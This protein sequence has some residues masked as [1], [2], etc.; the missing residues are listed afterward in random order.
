MALDR[1]SLDRLL[2]LAG[3]VG[4]DLLGGVQLEPGD[5]D[6]LVAAAVGH[7]QCLGEIGAEGDVEVAGEQVAGAARQQAHRRAGAG[8]G[9]RDRADGAVAAERADDV[10]ARLDRL[11]GL[12]GAG[13]VDRRLDEERLFPAQLAAGRGQLGAGRRDAVEL[14]R[15]DDDGRTTRRGLAPFVLAEAVT[16]RPGRGVPSPR[17]TRSTQDESDDDGDE[18]E[19]E[20]DRD[21]QHGPVRHG[22]D[23]TPAVA[24]R[25]PSPSP[26]GRGDR[27]SRISCVS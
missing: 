14:R 15:V 11:T 4:G 24:R 26:G 22:R 25:P 9:D 10:D 6:R 8:E 27:S 5:V 23:A 21:R 2:G 3:V 16:L 19:A 7:P 18:H 20:G 1:G 17:G 13:V 12:T